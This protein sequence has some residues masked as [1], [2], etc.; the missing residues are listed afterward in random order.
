MH[1]YVVGGAAVGGGAVVKAARPVAATVV[2]TQS[3]FSAHSPECRVVVLPLTQHPDLGSV[4]RVVVRSILALLV[5]VTA[6]PFKNGIIRTI[7]PEKIQ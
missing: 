7:L 5:I 6:K 3:R 1:R 4:C 2:S